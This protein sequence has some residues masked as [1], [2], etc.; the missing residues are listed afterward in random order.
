MRLAPQPPDEETVKRWA[1]RMAPMLEKIQRRFEEGADD[2]RKVLTPVQRIR[3]EA[4]RARFGL[5]LQFARNMLDHWRQGDFV[6]DDVWVPTDPKARAK[7]RARRRERRKALGKLA[8]EQ[9]PPPDQI[10][11]E[12]DA[13]ER[14]VR[15]AAERYGFDAG[16]RSAAESVLEEMKGRAFHHRDLHKQEIDALERRIASFSGK[17]EELEELKKQLVALY[18]PIDEMFKELKARIESLPTSE[19]RRRAGVSKA[20]PKEETRQPASSGKDQQRRN[21][22]TP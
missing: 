9:T 1:E 16:Q 2:F 21:P 17:D 19:Q 8:R 10:A 4:D 14:Y 5:G 15:E 12:V 6:E 22:S 13:W 3:F 20:E 18:G 7:R 11:L